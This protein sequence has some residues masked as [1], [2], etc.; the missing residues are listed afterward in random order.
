MNRK[1]IKSSISSTKTKSVLLNVMK[2]VKFL[3]YQLAQ[4]TDQ[5]RAFELLIGLSL[6]LVTIGYC[7]KPFI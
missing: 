7:S 6:F 3:M 4:M 1:S 2:S 5:N